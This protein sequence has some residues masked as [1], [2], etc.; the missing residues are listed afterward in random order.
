MFYMLFF[1]L[2]AFLVRGSSW[3]RD[4]TSITAATR[5]AAVT[6]LDP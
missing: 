6:M 3:A 4:Q 1:F 5:A 2:A